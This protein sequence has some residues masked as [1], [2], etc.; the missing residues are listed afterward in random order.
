[1]KSLQQICYPLDKE[2]WSNPLIYLARIPYGI[3]SAIKGNNLGEGR[4]TSENDS[5]LYFKKKFSKIS[6]GF[7]MGKK[8]HYIK[9]LPEVYEQW[10]TKFSSLIDNYKNTFL[11]N[12]YSPNSIS[13]TLISKCLK[14][15]QNPFQ[16]MEYYQF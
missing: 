16:F 4:S 11:K 7:Y 2:Q 15:F 1:M 10:G 13:S 14:T 12:R 3:E 6:T 5:L 8:V 9:V